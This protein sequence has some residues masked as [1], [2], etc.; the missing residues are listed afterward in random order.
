MSTE[1]I[2]NELRA[3]YTTSFDVSIT[4]GLLDITPSNIAEFCDCAGIE[5]TAEEYSKEIQM[6][7][8]KYQLILTI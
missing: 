8:E 1:E 7:E 4:N 5:N 6:L 2:E 3:E